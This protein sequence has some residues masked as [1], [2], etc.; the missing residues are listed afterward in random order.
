MRRLRSLSDPKAASP[1]RN[2][3]LWPI[4]LLLRAPGLGPGCCVPRRPR[5]RPWR[6]FRRSPEIGA[7]SAAVDDLVGLSPA[8]RGRS[9]V[10]HL[11]EGS[12]HVRPAEIART[13]DHRQAAARR[14][15]RG[16]SLI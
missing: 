7:T 1:K 16:L 2:L 4:S 12:P 15:P 5:S 6:R 14:I 3:T 9:I 11:G 10:T 8:A 13:A